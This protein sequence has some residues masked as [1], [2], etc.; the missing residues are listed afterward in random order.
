RQVAREEPLRLHLGETFARVLRQVLRRRHHPPP[1]SLYS[2]TSR[3]YSSASSAAR[4]TSEASSSSLPRDVSRRRPTDIIERT[5][6]G[7]SRVASPHAGMRRMP[8]PNQLTLTSRSSRSQPRQP[9]GTSRTSTFNSL[10]TT[11]SACA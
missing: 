2:A 5:R 10:P 1:G 11:N 7:R 3:P 4:S 9:H 6:G 8:V